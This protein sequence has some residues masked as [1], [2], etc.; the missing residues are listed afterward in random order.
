[1]TRPWQLLYSEQMSLSA[2]FSPQSVAVIGASTQVGSVGNDLVKNLTQGFMGK[3]YPVNPKGGELYGLP[4]ITDVKHLPRGVDLAVIAVPAPV[5]PTVLEQ[6][7]K[8]NVRAA[9]VISAGFKEVGNVALEQKLVTTARKYKMTLVGPNCLGVMN[10]HLNLNASFAPTMPKAGS[11][12]FISQSGALGVAVTDFAKENH[13]GFSKFL[14]IGNKAGLDEAELLE[15]LAA[16]D[17]TRVILLY[18]EQLSE[19]ERLLRVAHKIRRQKNPKPIIVL[20][21][22]QTSAGAAAAQSH[23]GSLAGND[24]LYDALFREAGMIRANTVEELFLYAESFMYNPLLKSDRVAVITNAGGVGILA[25]DALINEN[26]KLAELDKKTQT[27]LRKFLPESASV[28]NP[29]DILGDA[30]ADR[31]E[32]TLLVVAADTGVDAIV[33]LLTPQSMTEV[34]ATARAILS[35]KK[36][37][38]KPIVTSF[39]GGGRVTMGVNLLQRAEVTTVE[40]PEAAARGLGVVHRFNRWRHNPDKPLRYSVNKVEVSHILSRFGRAGQ[41]LPTPAVYAVLKAYR[42]PIVPQVIIT[43]EK[44]L[45]AAI[46]LCGPKMVM[47]IVSPDIVHKSDVGGVLFNVTAITAKESYRQICETVRSKVPGVRISGVQIMRQVEI[48]DNL[49]II[50]GAVRD[51]ALGAIVGV[52]MGGIFTETFNDA[53]FAL[54]P[55]TKVEAEDALRRLKIA[56]LLHGA[57]GQQPF[58]TKALLEIFGRIAQLVVDFPQIAEID[59]NPIVLGRRGK[60]GMILDARIRCMA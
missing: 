45:E 5:V 50:V 1:M 55:V 40:Y 2:V 8:R 35:A 7:G 13:L 24:A 43:K 39:L 53:A 27:A 51:T 32:Q 23:T 20:K 3:I 14:S 54:A 30:K 41:W 21:S 57:R 25:T 49:E 11:I 15:Y 18:V 28:H 44:D 6:A 9:I 58:D 17:A 37:T 29:V 56:P 33:V 59:I 34:D 4:V 38:K 36:V 22:G 31:Y 26:L 47:K 10:P 46:A 60:G 48:E 19:F 42:L 16:D 52:G 12:A